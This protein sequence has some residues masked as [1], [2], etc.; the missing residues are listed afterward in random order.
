MKEKKQL[1]LI[2]LASILFAGAL[3]IKKDTYQMLLFITAYLLVGLPIIAKAL[4]NIGHGDVFDENFLMTIATI[5][6]FLI[7]EYPEAVAVMLFY[8]VGELFQS[9]AVHRSRKSISQLMDICPEYANVQ[10]GDSF[11]Q[12]DPYEVEIGDMIL[13]KPGERVP[14]DGVVK[15]GISLLDTRALTGESVPRTIRPGEEIISGCINLETPL[16]VEVSKDYDNSTVSKIL[17]L[18][19]NAAGNKANAENFIT[20][21]A[22]YYT[23]FVVI[24]AAG[25]GFLPP[26]FLEG[27]LFSHWIYRALV[28]LVVSCPC[29]L[30]ISI[31][32]SFFGGIGGASRLGILVKGSNYLEALASAEIIAFDKTGT[33]TE[34]VFHVQKIFAAEGFTQEELLRLAA[35]GEMYSNHPI[36]R[37]ILQHYEEIFSE[38]LREED[39][40]Y[41]QEIPGQGIAC[42]YQ[43]KL[44]LLGN[45]I[46]MKHHRI[47]FV[48]SN[49]P[50]TVVHIALDSTYAGHMVV[51][52]TIKTDASLAI[53]ALKEQ[54]IKK[55]V[56]LTG[57]HATISEAIGATLHMDAVFAELLPEGKVSHMEALKQECSP[58][59]KLVFVG[60]GL[61]DAPVLAGADI[62]IAMG[63]MGSD[64]AIEA[65]DIVIMTDQP[66]K[67]ATAMT[68][69]KKTL[70]IVKQNIAF[71]LGVKGLVLLLGAWGMANMWEAVF[72]DVGVSVIAILNAI[73]A[74]NIKDLEQDLICNK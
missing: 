11:V 3:C 20:K 5:G 14:L 34:G 32:L 52:D 10:R 26:L 1:Q 47:S 57:D 70:T 55:T 31:P 65:A 29:A 49:V 33:L 74:L 39:V 61:N 24:T 17:E 18:V 50:G 58:K 13:V 64:A 56:M 8:Q 72:A 28:F 35:H 66:A 37:S 23:P 40:K 48:P 19:E 38:K 68:I 30:V 2:I 6:A 60:D 43:G 46:L 15:E 27:A 12:V 4:R 9:Y 22:R 16:F 71:A 21:F 53:A 42:Q 36:S 73:R 63:G 59:G 51:A 25:I 7:G 69:A 67:I 62:G 45:E 44:L 41:S 54:G